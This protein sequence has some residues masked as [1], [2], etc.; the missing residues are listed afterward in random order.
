MG[1][2]QARRHS[3]TI[4]RKM[5]LLRKDAAL[6]ETAMREAKREAAAAKLKAEHKAAHYKASVNAKVVRAKKDFDIMRKKLQAYKGTKRSE[7]QASD[8]LRKLAQQ[9]VALSTRLKHGHHHLHQVMHRQAKYVR[10]A[11][12]KALKAKSK[13]KRLLHHYKMGL[14]EL[15]AK[16]NKI[17]NSK[18]INAVMATRIASRQSLFGQ[19]QKK[20]LTLKQAM[21]SVKQ[22]LD[23]SKQRLKVFHQQAKKRKQVLHVAHAAYNNLSHAVAHL[24]KMAAQH[25][26][27]V[28]IKGPTGSNAKSTQK[29][30]KN[31]IKAVKKAASGADT[32]IAAAVVKDAAT[33][34]ALEAEK[35][36][37]PVDIDVPGLNS[38]LDKAGRAMIALGARHGSKAE[39][40]PKTAKLTVQQGT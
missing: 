17:H 13:L 21:A 30:V 7:K 10:K 27:A 33:A 14:Q 24:K 28:R 31:V 5:K 2:A 23:K 9:V 40:K 6:L 4:E 12:I 34:A 3:A 1:A 16:L 38:A 11:K 8:R 15:Q 36:T 20:L 26:K 19:Q 35:H 29:V 25:T 32:K 22:D 39:S 37:Q 18:D